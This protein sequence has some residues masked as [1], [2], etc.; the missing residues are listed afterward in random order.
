MEDNKKNFWKYNEGKILKDLEAYIIGTYTGHYT[1]GESDIQSI[2]LIANN[3]DGIAFAKSNIIK[4]ASRYGKKS[5]A[6]KSDALKILHYA[7]F[8]YHFSGHDKENI[9]NNYDIIG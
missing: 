2:D 8:L 3:G 5:L 9:K 4:Y 1:S 7:V 6:T